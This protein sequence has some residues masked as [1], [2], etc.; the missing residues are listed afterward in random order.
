MQT[1]KKALQAFL[2]HEWDRKVRIPL[3]LLCP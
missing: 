2:T 3:L 1:V